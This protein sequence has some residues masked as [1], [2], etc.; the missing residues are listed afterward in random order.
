[1]KKLLVTLFISLS[2]VS[3]AQ[4]KNIFLERSFWKTNPSIEII[5]QKIEEGNNVSSLN[6]NAFDGVVYAILE[7]V[8]NKTI[9]YMLSKKG[10]NVNKKTHDGR[11]YIFWAAYKGNVEIMKFVF[12]KGAKTTIIDTHGNTFLNFAAS[13][14]QLKKEVYDYSFKIGADITKEKNHDGAN[15]LLLIAPHLKDYKTVAYFIAN[16]ASLNDKDEAGNGIFEYAAKAGNTY[17]LKVLLEK[18]VKKGE[19]AMIFASKGFGRKKNTLE[20]YKFL[21]S[22]GVK[23]NVVDNKGRN[24]LHAIAYNDKNLSTYTYFINKGVVLNLQD[25]DGNSPFMNAANSNSLEVVKFLSKQIK[26]INQKNNNGLSALTMAVNRNTVNVVNFLIEKGADINT[27]DKEGNTLSYYLLNN[28]R[29]NK[30]EAFTAKLTI[31]QKNGLIINKLQN[32]K[33]T[34][35]HIATQRNNLALL[36]A[37]A[38]FKIDVNAINKEN[39]SALQ[40]AAMK[41][42]DDTIIKYLISIGADKKIKTDFGESIYDLA[43]ENEILKKKN[44]NITY[45]K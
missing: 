15:A 45:L 8:D 20:T 30:T 3:I 42:K 7:N 16:G 35:L 36:K 10:N 37:L 18:G 31:L 28:Y 2:F 23:P 29:E 21:E 40:I 24:P 32:S 9:K 13:T 4:E 12:S 41:G 44:I 33:N 26:N 5:D 38:I 43:S 11:T 27:K 14:G 22:L 17:F 19:N 39:L 25:N 6:N 1:M 34:L